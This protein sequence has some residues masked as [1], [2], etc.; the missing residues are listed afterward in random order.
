MAS[1]EIARDQW[2]EFLDRFSKGHEGWEVTLEV[3]GADEGAQVEFERA[4][5]VG[6]TSDLKAGGE[7]RIEIIVGRRGEPRDHST[8]AVTGPRALWVKRSEEGADE[9]LDIE[10]EDGT[11]N[12][13]IIE[14]GPSSGEELPPGTD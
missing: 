8:R 6:V 1:T 7:P 13:L 2:N 14:G 9:A 12:V 4:P 10:G 5:L 11:H 3:R